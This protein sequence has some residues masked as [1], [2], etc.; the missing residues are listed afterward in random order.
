[1]F[2]TK[3]TCL[4]A[5]F[6][7]L[8]ISQTS[9]LTVKIKPYTDFCVLNDVKENG[10]LTGSFVTSGY[11]DAAVRLRIYEPTEKTH[12]VH[13]KNNMKEGNWEVIADKE[14]EYKTCFKNYGKHSAYVSFE[15]QGGEEVIDTTGVT[16]EDVQE[17]IKELY[18]TNK[19]MNK[20]KT[21]LGFQTTRSKIHNG[22]LDYLQGQIHWSAIV[23]IATLALIGFAQIYILTGYFKK[24]KKLL[25]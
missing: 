10:K 20:I 14:G 6:A 12:V 9:G 22:N 25:V 8:L 24:Q 23:K 13:E 4:F 1:M 7:V 15:V 11:D 17:A 5:L 18:S 16:V 3:F 21:N 19:R 2:N